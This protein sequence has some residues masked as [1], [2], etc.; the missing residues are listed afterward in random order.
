MSDKPY[1]A[2]DSICEYK[3]IVEKIMELI[4]NSNSIPT[5]TIK[6]AMRLKK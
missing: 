1:C 3:Q 6:E 2:S 4:K 5:R